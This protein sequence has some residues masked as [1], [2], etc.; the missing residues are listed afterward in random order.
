MHLYAKDYVI[1]LHY[2]LCVC[3]VE[4]QKDGE[5]DRGEFL[6]FELVALYM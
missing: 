2:K 6:Y 4:R 1:R 5:N 3:S